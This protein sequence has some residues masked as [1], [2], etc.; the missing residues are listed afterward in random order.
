MKKKPHCQECAAK[1]QPTSDKP[2]ENPC[3]ACG[4]ELS[5][6]CI[7]AM[8][9]KFHKDCFKCSMCDEKLVSKFKYDP[10][11][12]DV[13]YCAKCY[14]TRPGACPNCGNRRSGGQYCGHCGAQAWDKF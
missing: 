5:G 4:K 11:D 1:L 13:L 14:P 6:A 8:G 7:S 12:P 3:F 9:K 2:P 10:M